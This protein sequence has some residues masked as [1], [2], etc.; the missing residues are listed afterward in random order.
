MRRKGDPVAYISI[1]NPGEE[2]VSL[3]LR[4]LDGPSLVGSGRGLGL[5]FVVVVFEVEG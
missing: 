4:I 3:F 1:F 5:L 2:L